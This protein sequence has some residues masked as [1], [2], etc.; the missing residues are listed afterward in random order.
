MTTKT[1]RTALVRHM[2]GGEREFTTTRLGDAL[3]TWQRMKCTNCRAQLAP[4]E[5]F[6][7]EFMEHLTRLGGMKK[8]VILSEDGRGNEV[9]E[10]L[11]ERF[12]VRWTDP[13]GV[14]KSFRFKF[15]EEGFD[16]LDWG[17]WTAETTNQLY[18][19][20]TSGNGILV[21]SRQIPR[22]GFAHV[23]VPEKLVEHVERFIEAIEDLEEKKS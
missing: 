11:P 16:L 9:V 8:P 19:E 15:T 1:T 20:K 13:N 21:E 10:K 4:N 23:L 5:N 3:T 6:T 22:K 12:V 14:T 2:C 17:G 18:V 7:A